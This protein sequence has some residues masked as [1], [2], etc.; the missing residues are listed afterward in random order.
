MARTLPVSGIAESWVIP[1][2][3]MKRGLRRLVN[4]PR[5]GPVALHDPQQQ[6]EVWFEDSGEPRNV[7]RNNVVVA[8]R[9]FT[10]GLMFDADSAPANG[11]ASRLCMRD[12]DSHQLLGAINLR[13]A[14]SI[15]LPGRQFRLFETTA[16]ENYSVPPAML[17]FYYL[18]EQWRAKRRLRKNP[19]NFSMAPTD[20]RCSY[21]FYIC[22]RPVVL[23]T[24]EHQD[25]SNMFPMD[26]IGPTD[27]PWFSMALRSTSP[28][29]RLMQQSRRMSLASVPV[30]YQSIVYEL[31]KHH[32]LPSVCLANLPFP[33]TL[34]P[35]FSLPV[36]KDA[37][38]VREVEVA[39]FH[40]V[41]SHVLFLTTL[42]SDSL[43]EHDG[44]LQ[45]FHAFGS[46]R[47]SLSH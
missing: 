34:S 35:T 3:A 45:L 15:S 29:V 25:A 20:L 27:S 38:R 6:V 43:P 30:E 13:Q 11:S 21:I 10:I 19:F 2:A 40:E 23:V 14:G 41:G 8:L 36:M 5:Y 46:C 22:P 12:A 31:G 7:T 42:V 17:R 37:L 47:K 4:L 28:A 16:C 33:V 32:R 44:H 9:P 24:V 26:L 18:R 39:E 1:I